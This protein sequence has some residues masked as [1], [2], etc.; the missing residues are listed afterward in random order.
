MKNDN[1]VQIAPKQQEARLRRFR[2]QDDPSE[3][4]NI[5]YADIAQYLDSANDSLSDPVVAGPQATL[6][7]KR[8]FNEYGIAGM[9]ETM[10]QLLGALWYCKM[11]DSSKGSPT[12]GPADV[13]LWNQSVD[14]TFKKHYPELLEPLQAARA[15]DLETLT[16]VVR[17][18]M[19]FQEM[20]RHYQP[21]MGWAGDGHL[22]IL[23]ERADALKKKTK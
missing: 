20:E 1:V 8:L 3:L 21:E 17:E 22:V 6:A 4:F 13:E 7:L 18:R 10:G 11:L 14:E 19:S 16:R 2:A 15:R 9:P 23:A 12:L 5:P